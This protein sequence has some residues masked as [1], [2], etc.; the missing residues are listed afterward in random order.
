MSSARS[1]IQLMTEMDWVLCFRQPK[2]QTCLIRQFYLCSLVTTLLHYYSPSPQSPRAGDFPALGGFGREGWGKCRPPGRI[3]S[4]T[5]QKGPV[6]G[7]FEKVDFF[8]LILPTGHSQKVP[9]LD[10]NSKRENG[11]LILRV[12]PTHFEI[13]RARSN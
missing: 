7:F 12:T 6:L 4:A 13:H 9:I 10:L 1:V 2:A 11:D 3:K 8:D 5:S